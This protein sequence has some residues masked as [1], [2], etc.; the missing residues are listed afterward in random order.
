MAVARGLC[1]GKS[2]SHEGS[3]DC[4]SCGR[5][6]DNEINK[7]CDSKI[8]CLVFGTM[9][10]VSWITILL[11]QGRRSIEEDVEDVFLCKVVTKR[12]IS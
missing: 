6:S 7:H 1:F 5:P 11:V 4:L 8:S 2:R 12:R 3:R 9:N 10:S